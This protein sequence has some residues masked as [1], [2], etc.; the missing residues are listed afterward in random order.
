V[1]AV[2]RQ[3]G[4]CAGQ[5]VVVHGAGM[6]GLTA[7]A[8]AVAADA[9]QVIVLEPEE[10]RRALALQFGAST[11]LDSARPQEEIRERVLGL[12]QGRGADIGMELSG[13]PAA[14]E[15]GI[16]LLREVGGGLWLL[17]QRVQSASAGAP[18]MAW[19]PEFPSAARQMRRGS[20]TDRSGGR[21]WQWY[22]CRTS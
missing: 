7:C 21:L 12:T 11:V 18:A 14:V 8:M 20:I 10:R 9:S 6:L 3:A 2:F 15:A 4:R 19:A 1:A 17:T 13:S 22:R 16:R 5:A